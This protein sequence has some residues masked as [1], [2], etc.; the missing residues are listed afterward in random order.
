MVFF[1]IIRQVIIDNSNKLRKY[2]ELVSN[3]NIFF[4][5]N[6]DDSLYML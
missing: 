1:S 3:F 2:F 5:G 4:G 6:V